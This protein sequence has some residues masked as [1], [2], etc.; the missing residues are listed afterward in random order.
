MCYNH[1]LQEAWRLSGKKKYIQKL[2]R[3]IPDNILKE[4]RS[5]ATIHNTDIKKY[6]I[7]G[8]RFVMSLKKT[9]KI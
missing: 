9:G 5:R 2:K 3:I 4:I 8:E 6:R 1:C 7:G